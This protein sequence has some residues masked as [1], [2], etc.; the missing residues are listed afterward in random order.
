MASCASCGK[1]FKPKNV[2]RPP[3]FCSPNCRKLAVKDRAKALP[4]SR[5]SVLEGGAAGVASAV[6]AELVEGKREATS[7]GVRALALA[8]RIDLRA[9]TGS[10][11]ASLDKQLA[12]TLAEALQGVAQAADPVDELRARRAARRHA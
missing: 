6:R 5:V 3:R 8:E 9:D 4:E 2:G 10:A 1:G 11:L 12:M 7:A